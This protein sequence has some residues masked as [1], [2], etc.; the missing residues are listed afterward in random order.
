[1]DLDEAARQLQQAAH[2]AQVAYDC[3]SLG[4]LDRAHT[5]SVTARAEADAAENVLR[6]V[7]AGAD[8]IAADL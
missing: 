8:N 1:M 3:I 2:D 7:L 4:D 5:N 6:A